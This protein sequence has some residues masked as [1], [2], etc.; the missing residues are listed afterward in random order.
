M[1]IVATLTARREP[2]QLEQGK[3]LYTSP[4]VCL[5][6]VVLVLSAAAVAPSMLP[7]WFGLI[8]IILA[9]AGMAY[10]MRIAIGIARAALAENFSSFDIF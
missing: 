2:G 5:L 4:I 9:A 10:G 3:K 8:A 1:F 6:G 7:R